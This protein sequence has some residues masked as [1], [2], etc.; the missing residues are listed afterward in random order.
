MKNRKVIDLIKSARGF[1]NNIDTVEHPYLEHA[2][3]CLLEA[4]DVLEN[5]DPVDNDCDCHCHHGSPC[6]VNTVHCRH[7]L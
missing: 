7:C 2:L 5:G 3:S 1:I 6:K 4:L